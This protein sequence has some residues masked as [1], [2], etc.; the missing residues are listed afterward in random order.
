MKIEDLRLKKLSSLGGWLPKDKEAINVW[1][2]NF[3]ALHK[4]EQ[5][6]KKL[7][8]VVQKLKNLIENDPEVYMLVNEMFSPVVTLKS[9]REHC[10]PIKDYNEMLVFINCVLA[11]APEF[12]KTNLVGFPINA[13][14]NCS[15]ATPAGTIFYLN[16]KVNKAF[17]SILEYWCKFLTSEE[18]IYVLNESSSGWMCKEAMETIGIEQYRTQEQLNLKHW[19]YT[20]WND[21]FT[22][23]FKDD[24]QRPIEEQ[25]NNKIIVSPC[26]ST[27]YNIEKNIQE[28]S[29][30]WIKE[31]PYSLK[32]ML[33]SE[34][35]YV[36]KF[37]GGTIYQSFLSAFNYHRWHSPVNGKVVKAFIKQG[38]YYAESL[39]E[40]FDS[41]GP[42][43][44][45]GY[46]TQVA[47]R[48]I[49][50]IKTEDIGFVGIITIG[51]AEVSSC[52]FTVKEN[53]IV[54]KGQDIGY[55]QYGGS[56]CCMIFE[57]NRIESFQENILP[58]EDSKI[59]LVNSKIATAK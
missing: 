36:N 8:P 2:K 10:V 50:I 56:S 32:F 9:L 24:K 53:D 1:L 45:Q 49:M 42:N 33:A 22:R 15:M 20:S 52:K 47:T 23:K 30:F 3:I 13:I 5:K 18:S 19:G 6:G 11:I 26:E 29:Q 41:A 16:K 46:I 35:K 27:P 44:S 34:D 12:N 4:C 17:Y 59:V 25:N 48:A 21:F 14:L 7:L 40:G 38:S 28:Y 58:T 54:K 57:P 37:I 51:M 39:S 55:F 31:Q 43:N